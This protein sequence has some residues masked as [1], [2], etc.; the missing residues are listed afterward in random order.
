MDAMEAILT[1]RSVRQYTDGKIP[2]DSIKSMLEAA[3][4]APSAGNQQPWQFVVIDD[5]DVLNSITN[6]HPYASMLREAPLAVVVCGD[7]AR[8]R[9]KGYWVQDCSAATQ[10]LLIAARA[11][12]LGAVWLGVYPLEDRVKGLGNLLSLPDTVTPLAVVSIGCPAIEQGAVDR[13]DANRIHR[14]RWG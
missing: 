2:E 5:R 4:S 1:R 8:E 3:M 12:G 14:N 6:V 11:L 7:L 10:N 9:F 13:F